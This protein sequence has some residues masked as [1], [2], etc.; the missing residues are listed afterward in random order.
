ML[1]LDT[2]NGSRA[3]VEGFRANGGITFPM[4]LNASGSAPST[5]DRLVVVGTDGTVK[6]SD[7]LISR[8]ISAAEAK[9]DELLEQIS[10]PT[11]AISVQQTAVD[12]GTI[13]AGQTGEQTITIQ[14]TGTADLEITG[15]ESDVS[16]L[17][18]D[19]TT[20]TVEAGG[21]QTVTVTFPSSTEGTFSGNIT[22]SSNDPNSATQTLSVSITVQPPLA[23]AISMQQTA[24]DFGTV[25]FAQSVQQT[26]TIANTGTAPLEITGIESDVSGLTFEPSMFTLEPDGSQIVTVTFPSSVEGTFSGSIIISSNDPE[27]GTQTLSVSVT[28]QPPPAPAITVQQTAVDF[29]TVA[30]AQPVQRTITI[31]NTGTAPLEITGIESD[32]SGLTFD[33]MTFTLAPG[34]SQMVTITF[35][36]ST[37]GTFSGNI[38]ISSNDPERAT[39]TLSVSVIVQPPPV[40]ALSVREIAID[41]GTVAFAQP[42]QHKITITNTGTAPLEITGIESDV[43]G[44][45]FD[46]VMF[47]LNPGGSRTVTVT[48]PSSVEGTFSGNITISSNDPDPARHT[49]SVSIIVQPPPVPAISVQQ[50]AI[51]FGTVAF[52][53]PVQQMITIEN[54]GTAP[55]EITGI[56]SDVSGL[57]FDPTMFTLNPGGSRTVTVTFPSSV[58]G[59]FS[60]NITISS[61]D[62][63]RAIQTLSVSVIVQPRPVPAIT[64][65]QTE[66]DFG[67]VAFAQPVQQMITIENTGTAPLEITGI[68]SDVSGLTFEPSMFTL[69]PDGSQIVTV[70]FPSSVE[71]TF[72]GL[73]SISSNDPERGTQT[74]SVSVIVQPPPVPAIS[75]QQTEIDFGTVAF[76]QPVQQTITIQNTGTA[77]LEITGIESDVS[78]LTF[79]PSTF[80][81]EPNSSKT[82]TVMFPSSTEGTF[83]GNI[84]I[85]S[86]DPERATQT[87]SVSVT[88]QPRPVPAIS[89]QQTAVDFGTV[90]FAQSV[91][92]MITVQ[93]TGTAT[94]EITGIESD[95]SGL[96]FE[97]SMFTLEPDGSQIVT[98]T[99]PSSVEGTFSGNITIS[100]NDPER[101]TQTLSVSGIVQPRPVPAISVQQTAIDFGTV[102]FAQPVQQMITVQNTGTATLEITGIE[103]DVSGLTFDTTMF[104]LEPNS[105]RTVTVTFPSSAEGTFSGSIII[106]SNDPDRATQTLSVSVI[107]QPPPVPAISVQQTAVEF[108]TIEVGQP[109]QQ[110]ITI[111]N[112]GTAPLEIT[113][114]ESDVSGLT[115]EPS[116]F[117]LEPDGSQ[118]VTVTFPSSTEGTF[119]GNITISSN[120][121]DR[122]TQTLSVSVIVQPRPVP[123][124]TVQQKAID[125]GT[126]AFAQP[127]QQTITIA[128]T[129]TAPLEITGIESDVSGLT[130][131]PSVFTLEPDGSQTVTITFPSSTEGTFSGLINILS[132]DPDRAKYTVSV[133]VIVQ[134][135]PVPVLAVQETAIDFGT[136]AFAQP[137]QQTITVQNTGTAPL[138][139]TGIES[140]VSGLTVEPSMFTLEPDGSQTVTVT[141]PSSVEGTFSGNIT[142]SSNDPDR[143][144]QTLSVS[145]IV[146]PPPAPAISIQQTAIDFGTVAFAQP[147]QQMITIA[148]TGTAPLE[149]TGI[150]SDVS[151][152]TFDPAMFTLSP[153]SSRTVTVTFPSSTEG[154]FSGLITIS[155]NDPDR[156]TQTLSVSVIVQAAPVPAI[157]VQ[158]TSI[159]FGTVA[160]AQSVQQTITITNTGTASLEVTGIESDVSGLTFDTTMFT[161]EPNGSQTVTVTFPSSTE[162]TFSGNITISSNDPDQAK[163][164]LSIS[165]IVQPP[166][167]PAIAVQQTAVDFG[168][169]EFAQTVQQTITVTNTGTAP[170]EIMGI[171][172]DVS[173]LTFEPA[174]FTLSPDSSRTV[175][176]TFPSSTEGT[177]SGNI[178]IS[179]NDPD[180]ATSTLSV[181]VIVQAAPAPVLVVGETAVD[182]GTIDAEK[183][184]QQ[185]FTI[186]NTGTAPLE[187]TSIESDVSGLTFDPVMFTLPPDSSRT[188]TITFPKPLEGTF[189]GNI[190]ILSNDPDRA[191]HT[192]TISGVVQPLSVEAKSDFDGNG[193]IEFADFLLFVSAFGSS[194]AQYDID[195]N[196]AVDFPD[197]LLFVS[198]F[199]KTVDG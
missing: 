59:T 38:T 139:I 83:S 123:A 98:V 50:T 199:G 181:S 142:I 120:D 196:G 56:E 194:E 36:S 159:D 157:S 164:T 31:T 135:P 77:P 171:E 32:V 16:G 144:T 55:L 122:A 173:G 60:G 81:L 132:N 145:V 167:A 10:S 184:V 192:L 54:T 106:S 110:M 37:A 158:E 3:Q 152:L 166:P 43:S 42:V 107:V 6:F 91:Q 198:V 129:G 141:F 28:V 186:T 23:P 22:I 40:P 101:G 148:N 34:G 176:V 109:V 17:T 27:R 134:P 57:T 119:S 82:V 183:T 168:T 94:L 12:F 126:V 182:F 84:T 4:L 87:L 104:T 154:T 125:F 195:R 162:G 169:V 78:G 74:L 155:S 86:N 175:T 47:T 68:E 13:D 79:E 26:I 7:G 188:I 51:D 191:T 92:Q 153:D 21:S 150:E 97:P 177:F 165:V 96:T 29:G 114:I 8:V 127:V 48:F 46:P 193:V 53:Q 69:E 180:R 138:E 75:V 137:V 108:G 39:Q 117:T 146:Q 33:T 160:F 178:T 163:H 131:E 121:P 71:G 172:S 133:S 20:F 88:V 116:M 105:S 52:A 72:S 130:F 102:A 111:A 93:N 113:G 179:S 156:A 25:A 103:S 19:T 140:D 174:M 18:F 64:V 63:D 11:P 124:I 30:F 58:E 44:L 35:P 197:F 24:V 80:T 190:T 118:I 67:T 90:A 100:S 1:G 41:F 99:F 49:V 9:V 45:A 5:Y 85:S 73:I 149:I 136:V 89:V 161:L 185:T 61:N 15:I 187:I 65:Q 70:T 147:V 151:G 2:W 14:N 62:P 115:V 128:N 95:V 66:I 170:L 143:A 112:T 189:S 76:A